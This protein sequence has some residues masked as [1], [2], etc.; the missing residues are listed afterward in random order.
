[1]SYNVSVIIRTKNESLNIISTLNSIFNQYVDIPVEVIIVDSGS[2]DGTIELVKDY[3]V[4][5]LLI[6][7]E[8]FTFGYSLNFGIKHSIGNIICCISAHCLPTDSLWLHRITKPIL[9][10]ECHATYGRQI[11]IK[12]VNPFEEF[13]FYK[14]FPE[15]E[16]KKGRVAFSNANCAFLKKLWEEV[17]FDED[18]PSWEDYLWYHLLKGKYI[19]K[20]IPDACVYHSHP[21]SI[22]RIKR[23]AYQDGMSFRYMRER[24]GLNI[25]GDDSFIKNKFIYILKDIVNHG[26]FFFEQKYYKFILALPILKMMS[27]FNYLKGYNTIVK[28]K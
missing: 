21:F 22:G 23:I 28:T 16:K 19:F 20:Y 2:T 13:S 14:H 26:R 6:S 5:T 4:K 15:G 3:D 8:S 24:Y 7:E 18:I 1:M 27:Y 11:P 17:K 25:F 12:S 9:D 10:G